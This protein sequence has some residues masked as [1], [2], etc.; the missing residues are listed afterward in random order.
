[1][2]V[3]TQP[4]G[5]RVHIRSMIRR[6]MPE[7]LA[8]DAES[9]EHPWTE[10]DFIRC[11][12]QRNCNCAVAEYEEQVVGY[13]LYEVH[14]ARIHVLNFA[15]SPA[16][17]RR[18]VGAQ[19]VGKLLSKLTPNGRRRIRLEISGANLEAQL[20][21][22][23]H[24]FRAVRVLHGHYGQR[25]DEDAYVLEYRLPKDRWAPKN[26]IAALINKLKE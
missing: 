16:C 10:E 22:Q 2:N 13:M 23:T 6:D 12:H 1:M 25:S 26:R 24:G 5:I 3:P 7:I 20:F 4:N 14:K 18:G 17:R 8:I 9:F 15:V 19:M 21:F 11:Q